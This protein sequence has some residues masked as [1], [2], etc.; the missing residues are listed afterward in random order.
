[1]ENNSVENPSLWAQGLSSFQQYEWLIDCYRMRIDDD[2]A[3]GGGQLRGLYDPDSTD[4]EILCDFL[5]FCKQ[6]ALF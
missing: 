1:M 5:K 3:L 6:E 4:L 2:Y